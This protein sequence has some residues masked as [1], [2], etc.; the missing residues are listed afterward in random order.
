MIE[1]PKW[2]AVMRMEEKREQVKL[3]SIQECVRVGREFLRL[4]EIRA[5]AERAIQAQRKEEKRD[6]N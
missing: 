2:N 4:D 1:I 6:E 3:S 5:L